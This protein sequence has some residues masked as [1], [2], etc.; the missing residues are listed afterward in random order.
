MLVER[1][2]DTV[3]CSAACSMPCS[4]FRS[5]H[6]GV[7]QAVLWASICGCKSVLV[8][9][10]VLVVGVDSNLA[11]WA[12]TLHY[13]VTRAVPF[14]MLLPVV[15]QKLPEASPRAQPIGCVKHM[16]CIKQLRAC[17][18]VL[19]VVLGTTSRGIVTLLWAMWD[20]WCRVPTGGESCGMFGD[21]YQRG[22]SPRLFDHPSR[23]CRMFDAHASVGEPPL[24]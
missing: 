13:V 10:L 20:I 3:Y 7:T 17:A 19:K 16:S 15:P 1:I 4:M 5:V 18:V 24:A 9:L 23:G 2:A 22:P 14:Q 6:T 11:E 8:W 21:G 12:T